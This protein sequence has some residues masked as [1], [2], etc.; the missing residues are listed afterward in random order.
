VKR[1]ELLTTCL[2]LGKL[3]IAPGTWGSLP[4]AVVFMAAGIWFGNTAAIVMMVLLL[5]G[6]CAATALCSPSVMATT[7]RKDP[8]CIVS[9]EVAGQSLALLLMQLFAPNAGFCLTAAIGFGLFRV[10]DILKPWPCRRLEKLPAGWGILADDLAAGLWAAAIWIAGRHLD[11]LHGVAGLFC[12]RGAMSAGFAAFLGAVQGLTE[13]LPVSS[14]GHLVFFES[15]ADGVHTE[16]PEMLLFDLCLHIGTVLS[17]FVVFWHSIIRFFRQLACSLSGRLSPIQRYQQKPSVRFILLAIVA[18]FTTAIFYVLFKDPLESARSLK[19]VASMWLVT[20]G[21]LTA[22]DYRHGHKGLRNFGIL[23]AVII[24]IF[25]GV[26]IL[27]GV[28]RSGA[29]V[30][31]AILLGLRTRWAIEFSFL[32]SIPAILGGVAIQAIKNWDSLTN[33]AIAPAYLFIG[34]VSAFIM[35]V[36]SLKILIKL[37][38]RRKLRYFAAYCAIL[39]AIT[40]VYFL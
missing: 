16:S 18:T 14:S 36:I 2:G 3:P 8:G 6:G 39:A 37:S 24:G 30:C 10:F 25:Q 22:A 20:A 35:G 1:D 4:P 34:M 12:E 38:K 27:P 32:I 17:I 7:G 11:A 15:F 9:D 28:S 19:V 23:M 31:A 40:W 33:G 13:F 5:A 21:L 26:A 29:T